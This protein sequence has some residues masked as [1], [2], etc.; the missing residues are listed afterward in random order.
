MQYKFVVYDINWSEGVSLP[1]E[2]EVFLDEEIVDSDPPED[3]GPGFDE[4]ESAFENA[5]IEALFKKTGHRPAD[6]DFSF[7][8]AEED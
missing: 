1:D 3:S 7:E 6:N 8:Q 2:V 4:W 5:V